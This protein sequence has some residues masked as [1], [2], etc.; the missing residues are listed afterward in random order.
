MPGFLTDAELK[1]SVSAALKQASPANLPH[2]WD[3]HI[4]DANFKAW[5][6]IEGALLKRQ[7]TKAQIAAWS[8]G[9]IIQKL[10]GLYWAFV[11]GAGLHPYDDRFIRQWDQREA[12][13]EIVVDSAGDD[14]QVPAGTPFMQFGLMRTDND[15]WGEDNFRM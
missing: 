5:Q 7:F 6:D 8:Q 2:V 11:L 13:K 10:Q 12:L 4:T 14:G 1:T 3:T 9:P 15:K